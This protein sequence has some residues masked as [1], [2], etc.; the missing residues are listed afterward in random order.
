MLFSLSQDMLFF[1]SGCSR[2]RERE[3][4]RERINDWQKFDWR[5]VFV[6]FSS[7]NDKYFV[8]E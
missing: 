8:F 5:L 4:E 1:I 3:R 2:K 6:I 7:R